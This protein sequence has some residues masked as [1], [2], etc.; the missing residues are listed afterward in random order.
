[1]NQL[2]ETRRKINRTCN[3]VKP[4]FQTDIYDM[5]S[6]SFTDLQGPI[7]YAGCSKNVFIEQFFLPGVIEKKNQ[8]N[9]QSRPTSHGGI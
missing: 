9:L 2:T 8:A 7:S 5:S 3:S 1:M 6:V 4:N